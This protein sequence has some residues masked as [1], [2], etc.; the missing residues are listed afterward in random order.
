MFQ[1]VAEYGNP[2]GES[3]RK[4]EKWI[5]G[6][7]VDIKLLPKAKEAVDVLWF[8]GDFYAYH[9]R[10]I[11]A[12]QAMARVYSKMG[13]DFGILGKD[14]RCD[15]DSQRLAGEPGLFEMMAEH[16]IEQFDKYTPTTPSRTSTPSSAANT[17]WSTTPSSSPAGCSS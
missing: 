8:V 16:N 6:A 15:G 3:A 2:F 17:T 14:E 13:V 5:K 10:G 11:D 1:A 12:A 9:E 4:R 7:G